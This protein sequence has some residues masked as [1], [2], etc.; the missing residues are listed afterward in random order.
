MSSRR[1]TS[2]SRIAPVKRFAVQ[3][4]TARVKRKLSNAERRLIEAESAVA[5]AMDWSDM[6]PIYNVPIP[7]GSPSG[8]YNLSTQSKESKFIDV[9]LG[10]SPGQT[11]LTIGSSNAVIKLLNGLKLGTAAFNRIGNKIAMKSLYW[12]VAF[13][14]SAV[15]AD[16]AVD[17]SNLDV[18][19]RTMVVYDKQPNGATFVLGDLLSAFSGLDNTTARTIDVNSP[20]NLN[21][22][23]R[24]IVLSDK[25]Y[26]LSS[27]STTGRLIKKYKRLNTAVSYKSG[28]T[29]GDITDITSGALF[30]LCWVDADMAGV[31]DPSWIVNMRGDIRLR[32][33]DD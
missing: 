25:R 11:N 27:A 20:N 18:P 26:I 31:T 23:D 3:P 28:A 24:F 6:R 5:D 2:G 12:S 30:F 21:N 10:T 14:L 13:G 33:Q 4:S 15:D 7:S 1:F 16:P 29:V 19:L 9:S 32:F 17:L 8:L 22:R